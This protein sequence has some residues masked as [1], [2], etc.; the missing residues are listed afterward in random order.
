ML[1]QIEGKSEFQFTG[2]SNPASGINFAALTDGGS[3]R[4]TTQQN[5]VGMVDTHLANFCRWRS[6]KR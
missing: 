2:C 4:E 5:L 3:V 1:K 6:L